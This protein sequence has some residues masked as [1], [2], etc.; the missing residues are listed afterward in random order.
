MIFGPWSWHS[1]YTIHAKTEKKAREIGE[2]FLDTNMILHVY[3]DD[4]DMTFCGKVT[5]LFYAAKEACRLVWDRADEF[6]QERAEKQISEGDWTHLDQYLD[7]GYESLFPPF[8]VKSQLYFDKPFT[9][10]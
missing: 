9:A 8:R 10:P 3:A 4:L 7:Y 2:Q 1:L 6:T 5:D